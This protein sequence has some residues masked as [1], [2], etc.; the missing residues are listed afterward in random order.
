MQD[1]FTTQSYSIRGP[2]A[3]RMTRY[4]HQQSASS[5]EVVAPTNT[6]AKSEIF[7]RVSVLSLPVALMVSRRSRHKTMQTVPLHA[8][9]PT[10][11]ARMAVCICRDDYKY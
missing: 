11:A 6:S 4:A 3:T 2:A 1:L 7:K 8:K 5:L 10:R 9:S